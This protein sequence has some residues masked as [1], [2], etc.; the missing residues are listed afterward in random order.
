VSIWHGTSDDT[1]HVTNQTELMQQWTDVNG[2]GPAEEVSDTVAGYP[3]KLYKDASGVARVEAYTLTRM[4]HGTAV[5]PR[6]EFPGSN[7]GC[8]TA[9][10]F[11]L[12]VDICSTY[13]VAKFFGLDS[14]GGLHPP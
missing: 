5:D 6:F 7:V 13:Y 10:A 8:G 12:D 1:V 9:G 11:I 14:T 3:H 4:G 2:V